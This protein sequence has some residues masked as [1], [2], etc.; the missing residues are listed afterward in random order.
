MSH[1]STADASWQAL[2]AA[3]NSFKEADPLAAV[4]II[5]P[6]LHSA[7]DVLNFVGR[8]SPSSQG[9]VNIQ[10]IPLGQW[11]TSLTRVLPEFV[12]RSEAKALH[13]EGAVRSVVAQDAGVFLDLRESPRTI[14]AIAK[15]AQVLEGIAIPPAALQVSALTSDVVRIHHEVSALLKSGFFTMPEVFEAASTLVQ[16]ANES[17]GNVIVFLPEE[18]QHPSEEEFLQVVTERDATT[19]IRLENIPEP[20][21]ILSQARIIT[22]ADPEEESRAIARIVVS[23]ISEGTPGHRIAIAYTSEDPYRVLL[24]R[25]LDDAGIAV[26]GTA[27]RQLSDHS[28]SRHLLELLALPTE[29]RLSPVLVLNA[30]AS[31]ALIVERGSLPS[32]NKLEKVYRKLRFNVDT[33]SSEDE[34]AEENA[35]DVKIREQFVAY[36]VALEAE[37]RSVQDATAWDEVADRLRDFLESNFAPG[38]S[39]G[40]TK[41]LHGTSLKEWFGELSELP[42]QLRSLDG[43]AP[44]PSA[45]SVVSELDH[46]ITHARRTRHRLGHGVSVSPVQDCVA[47]DVDLLIVCGLAEGFAPPRFAPDPLLPEEF[48]IALDAGLPTSADRPAIRKRQFFTAL[49]SSRDRIILTCPRGDLRGAGERVPSRWLAPRLN[50][51]GA[52]DNA[53]NVRSMRDGFAFGVPGFTGPAATS[54]E[55]KIREGLAA[56]TVSF[57]ES[58]SPKLR[59]DFGQAMDLI[60]DRLERRFTR[61]NGNL[62]SAADQGLLPEGAISPTS[63]E[64]Y[65]GWPLSFFFVDILDAPPLD[66]LVLSSEMDALH[67]GNLLH[68]VLERFVLETSQEPD[69]LEPEALE[70]L[71]QEEARAL[72]KTYGAFWIDVFFDR[73]VADLARELS[74]WFDVHEER[75]RAGY[76][77]DGTERVFGRPGME[78]DAQNPPVVVEFDDGLVLRFRGQI[79][80][81]DSTPEGGVEV[82]DYKSGNITYLEKIAKNP[83]T[84]N[85]TKFQLAIYGLFALADSQRDHTMPPPI[86]SYWFTK[87]SGSRDDA[88]DAQCFVSITLDEATVD[89]AGS[90]ITDLARLIQGGYFPPGAPLSGFDRYTDLQ[91]KDTITDLWDGMKHDPALAPFLAVFG[92]LEEEEE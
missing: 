6:G 21:D 7:R 52:V 20:G 62:T 31:G 56:G 41:D 17:V 25:A 89:Q 43:I 66:D 72:K 26:A 92:P 83:P 44:S 60:R 57:P 18:P 64:R 42:A 14:Q 82:I 65:A 15:S 81:L 35:D 86:A 13:R 10:V 37:I 63:L 3:V 68:R 75:L 12:N 91:T 4:T 34:G 51:D 47:R 69:K 19:V 53:E 22:A 5:T 2:A 39:R 9:L 33:T 38:R 85:K 45:A 16:S 46:L 77:V 78:A 32:R 58:V 84:L 27:P 30:L 49:H 23:A 1:S 36:L 76:T 11:A 8:H 54:R 73:A 50:F 40:R 29:Q 48:L 80:R 79:D 61:F 90:D 70:S 28:M 88:G 71:L 67:R 74:E 87:A 24:H 55:L 59:E